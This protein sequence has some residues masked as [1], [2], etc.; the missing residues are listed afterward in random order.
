MVTGAST[1]NL[2]IVLIDAR[3]GVLTQSK[4]H[5]F[6]AS[7]LQIPHVIVAINKMD[8][9]N[10]SEEV[11]ENIRAEYNAFLAKLDISDLT[12]IPISAL[13]GDNVVNKS[14]EMSWYKGTPLLQYLEDVEISGDRNLIDLRFPVQYV[15]RPNLNFRG[16]CGT[17]ASGIVRCGDEITILPSRKVSHIKSIETFDGNQDYAFPPQSVTLCL[18]DEIDIS[19]GDMIVHTGNQ[20]KVE[21]NIEAMLVWMSEEKMIINKPY[22]IKHTV[23]EIRG[24]I[25]KSHYHIDA[26]NLHRHKTDGLELNEIGRVSLD[27]FKPIIFDSYVRNRATGSII[28]IDPMSNAT[29]AAGMIIERRGPDDKTASDSKNEPVSNNIVREYSLVSQNVRQRIMRQKPATI[30]MTGLSGS[31]KSTIAKALEVKLMELGQPCYLLDGD[32]VRHG[33]NRDLGFSA[34]DRSENIR[35]IAEVSHLFNDSGMIVITSFI[36]PYQA[37]R[38]GA[39]EIIGKEQF[40]EVFIDASIDTCE[41]RDPK[42]LYAKARKGE[43]PN[44]TG[45]SAPYEAPETAAIHIKTDTTDVTAAVD[46]IIK[47]I[48]DAGIITK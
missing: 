25:T 43:I 18:E 26:D 5:G 38:T 31:G 40:I 9:V 10:Y 6:I 12:Y 22:I 44:F 28:L 7:L 47:Y 39:G 34:E 20:P 23:S 37:D 13:R 11:Y 33:L 8:L 36:S 42:G 45:I 41:Q 3:N 24:V 19:R 46:L 35:R 21:Y 32:N 17:V 27:L 2:A 16:Y 1:A 48:I 15:N 14:D 4:R 30:W 29:I